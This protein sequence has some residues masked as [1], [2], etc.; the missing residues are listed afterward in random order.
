MLDRD[1]NKQITQ[2]E[3]L[4]Q[5]F[6]THLLRVEFGS[7]DFLA[8]CDF[9]ALEAQRHSRNTEINSLRLYVEPER[10]Q[11]AESELRITETRIAILESEIERK[12][13]TDTDYY[14]SY[15]HIEE[16]MKKLRGAISNE[17]ESKRQEVSEESKVREKKEMYW[18]MLVN[19]FRDVLYRVHQ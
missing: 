11:L 15:S 19:D 6:R 2:V 9:Y 17:L 10:R 12:Q 8:F 14:K 13:N 1:H 7:T 5:E 4:K 3:V 18:D 16:Q